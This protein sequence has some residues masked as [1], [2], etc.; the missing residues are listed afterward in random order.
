MEDFTTA[1]SVTRF[2]RA[3]NSTPET[4][5]ATARR[6]LAGQYSLYLPN[7]AIFVFD[8][9]CDRVSE[10]VAKN[11]KQWKFCPELWLLWAEVWHILGSEPLSREIRAKS[12]RRVKTVSV[13]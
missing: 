8:L 7:S 10:F 2:L 13:A 3:K 5:V 12:F 4:V 6:L 9:V 11:F 1:E